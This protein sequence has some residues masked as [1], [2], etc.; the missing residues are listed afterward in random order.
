MGALIVSRVIW[1]IWIF[2]LQPTGDL[3]SGSPVG[4]TGAELHR[5]GPCLHGLVVSA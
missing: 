4:P 1:D 2:L 3:T 5:S